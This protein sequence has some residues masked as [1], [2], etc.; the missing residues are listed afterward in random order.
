MLSAFVD[1][2]RDGQR[3]AASVHDGVRAAQMADAIYESMGVGG[4]IDL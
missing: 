3:P 2:V 1:A 4:A